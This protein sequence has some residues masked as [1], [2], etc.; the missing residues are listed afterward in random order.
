MISTGLLF[1]CV[2]L[3]INGLL[4]L[5]VV[6]GKAGVPTN[7]LVGGMQVIFPTVMLIQASGDPAVAITA[8]SSYVFGFTYLYVAF[9]EITGASGEGLGWF[10]LFVTGSTLVFSVLNFVDGNLVYGVLWIGW[11]FLWFLFFLILARGNKRI[12]AMGGWLTILMGIFTVGASGVLELAGI[13]PN[14]AGAAWIA[15]ALMVVLIFLSWALGRA[16]KQMDAKRPEAAA[17]TTA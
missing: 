8:S 10:S 5:G 14:T 13:F 1:S 3:V 4:L 9:N 6:S 12:E 2:A 7:L 16:H 15:A 17:N 11:G